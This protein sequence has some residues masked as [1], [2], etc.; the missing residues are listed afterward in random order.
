MI[1]CYDHKRSKDNLFWLKAVRSPEKRIQGR[2]SLNS[3][4]K[5]IFMAHI[6]KTIIQG[7]INRICIML[8]SVSHEN[9]GCFLVHILKLTSNS[10][11]NSLVIFFCGKKGI[12]ENNT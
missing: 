3:S 12:S 4:E 8:G 6:F 1:A 10:L 9:K 2:I 5:D 11:D 7:S